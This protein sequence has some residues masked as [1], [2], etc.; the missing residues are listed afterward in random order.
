MEQLLHYVWRHRIYPLQPLRTTGGEALEVID[1]GLPNCHAG[2]DFFNAKVKIGVTLWAGD[3]EVHDRASD[4]LRHGHD[5]DRTYDRVVLHV[6]GEADCDVCRTDGEPI[7]QLLLPCPDSVR[8]RYDEL[9]LSDAC[10]P[11]RRLLSE[12]PLLK[13]HS[14]L[15]SLQ[16]ERLRQKAQAVGERLKRCDSRWEDAFFVTLARNFG[17][18]LNSDAFEAWAL[19]L[20]FRAVDKHR[21]SLFQVE[22]L[23]FGTAGLLDETSADDYA[24]SLCREYAYLSRKF[25]LSEP[26][27]REQWRFLRL[28]PAG[29]PHVR[30]AQLASIYHREQSLLSRVLEAEQ[31]DAVRSLFNVRLADYWTVHYSFG[32]PSARRTGSLSR[33]TLDL[34]VLNTVVPFLY[35]Y[36]LYRADD[37]LCDRALR[38]LETLQPENNRIIRSWAEAGLAVQ[39]AADS[40][41]VLQL[42][43]EYCDKRDCLRCRFGY[44]YLKLG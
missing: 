2:P 31:P 16:A 1:P 41:A 13:V 32:K 30:L 23:F 44:E 18:G 9:C 20:P 36:G 6:V 10:P 11:C 7:P 25:S 12:L 35:A 42:Q 14:W 15:A 40:Q 4:W 26:L 38:F 21:D 28:R 22:A 3:V 24:R 5:R 17:F 27:P 37:A 29:F 19:R 39:S 8:R 43:K 33:A 34:L